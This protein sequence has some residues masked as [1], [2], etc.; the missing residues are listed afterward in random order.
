MSSASA[1]NG[2]Y[3]CSLLMQQGKVWLIK[4]VSTGI[5]SAA[6]DRVRRTD[7]CATARDLQR[8][9]IR[10]PCNLATN[11]RELRNYVTRGVPS[12]LSRA[13][14]TAWSRALSV[15]RLSTGAPRH[16]SDCSTTAGRHQTKA[17]LSAACRVLELKSRLIDHV[18]AHLPRRSVTVSARA[19]EIDATQLSCFCSTPES[20]YTQPWRQLHSTIHQRHCA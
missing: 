12:A 9:A 6:M 8:M 10:F 20:Y 3:F 7:S 18:T 17:R 5:Q 11:A 2:Q 14:D 15:W 1:T 13:A 16:W 19:Q 4:R